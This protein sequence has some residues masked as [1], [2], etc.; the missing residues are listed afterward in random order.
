MVKFYVEIYLCMNRCMN[1]LHSDRESE[2]PWRTKVN[3][4]VA[5]LTSETLQRS[6]CICLRSS[7][8]LDDANGDS[9]LANNG[10]H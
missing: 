10:G 5:Q 1:C 8:V 9:L 2:G 7:R 4:I 3:Q 6:L